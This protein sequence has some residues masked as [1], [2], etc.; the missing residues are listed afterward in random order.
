[1]HT[2]YA[3]LWSLR[4]AHLHTHTRFL[5]LLTFPRRAGRCR[6]MGKKIFVPIAAMLPARMDP[7][8]LPF[9]ATT[10]V[11]MAAVLM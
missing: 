6:K 5:L 1:M 2:R 4:Y 8:L 7:G 11:F 10:L 9:M 3:H